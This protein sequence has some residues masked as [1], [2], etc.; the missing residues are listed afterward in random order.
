MTQLCHRHF[1]LKQCQYFPLSAF[2]IP[3][4]RFYFVIQE[5]S[6]RRVLLNRD[7]EIPAE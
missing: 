1:L 7:D 4:C 3:L 2:V 5:E 6:L